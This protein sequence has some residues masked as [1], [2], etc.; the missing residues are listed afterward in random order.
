M[1]PRR[2]NSAIV[3]GVTLLSALVMAVTFILRQCGKDNAVRVEL[4]RSEVN[5]QI[6]QDKVIDSL[7]KALEKAEKKKSRDSLARHRRKSPSASSS[8]SKLRHHLDE[9]FDPRSGQFRQDR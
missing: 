1:T 8:P 4:T 9:E 3:V 7:E 5:R 2:G 6:E